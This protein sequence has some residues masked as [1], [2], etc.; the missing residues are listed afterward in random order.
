MTVWWW[1]LRG[2]GVG[3]LAGVA[4][5]VILVGRESHERRRGGM[6]DLVG[7]PL[8]PD[9]WFLDV[10]HSALERVVS[11]KPASPPR[12]ASDFSP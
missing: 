7:A 4:L 6:V 11:S 9:D 2:F 1:W 3:S 12:D 8:D 5:A 10:H